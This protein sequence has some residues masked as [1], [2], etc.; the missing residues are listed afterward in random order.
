MLQT[1][2]DYACACFRFEDRNAIIVFPKT[3]PNG[4][5]ALKTEYWTAFPETELM[6]LERGFH[7]AYLANESRFAPKRD[8]DAKARFVDYIA[9][10]YGL[11]D[12]CVP[13][14]MSCGG[15]HA[16]RFAGYYPEKVACMYI[17]APVLSYCD[18]PGKP[19]VDDLIPVW[20]D[21][22]KVTYPGISRHQLL[23][24]PHHPLNMTDTLIRNRTPVVMV[25]GTADTLV[26]HQEN[27]L[28][29]EDAMAGLDFFLSIPVPG[30]GHHPH[31][32]WGDNTPVVEFIEKYCK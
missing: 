9:R 17:D 13:I 28:L 2:G 24:F 15:A 18:Y 7:I 23:T 29:L 19:G 22:F 1:L 11:K 25:Y 14:G 27:A 10:E 5:W 16:V 30:R 32:I 31:S 4:H 26:H 20:E 8:C 21:E 3:T 12:K 6:L